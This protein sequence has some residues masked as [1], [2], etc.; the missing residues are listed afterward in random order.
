MQN[1]WGQRQIRPALRSHLQAIRGEQR[2]CRFD[3]MCVCMVEQLNRQLGKPA[4]KPCY[5]IIFSNTREREIYNIGFP[6]KPG[7]R[8]QWSTRRFR[9]GAVQP[10]FNVTHDLQQFY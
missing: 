6:Q 4:P 5:Q 10:C 3:Y 9:G 1:L 7:S 8:K 2:L